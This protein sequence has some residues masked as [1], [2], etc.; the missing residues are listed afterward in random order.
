MR[1]IVPAEIVGRKK[2]RFY[3]PIDLWIKDD[4]KP[5]VEQF[6]SEKNLQKH[7]YF[8]YSY[9]QHMLKNYEKSRLYY[10]RQLWNLLTFEIWH[11]IYI[12]GLDPKEVMQ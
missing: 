9:V 12:E 4:L 2:Q 8:N 7:G 3:V 11:R 1:Q 10:A 5:M 6:L